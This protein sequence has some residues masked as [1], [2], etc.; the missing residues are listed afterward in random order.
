M[1]IDDTFDGYF[2]GTGTGTPARGG[3][4]KKYRIAIIGLPVLGGVVMLAMNMSSKTGGK[5]PPKKQESM[6]VPVTPMSPPP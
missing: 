1:N 3:F 6:I 2:D 4:W 5:P